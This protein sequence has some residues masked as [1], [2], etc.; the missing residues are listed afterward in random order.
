MKEFSIDKQ[1]VPDIMKTT[2]PEGFRWVD[3]V[4]NNFNSPSVQKQNK[5]KKLLNKIRTEIDA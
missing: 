1:Y 2:L 5:K 3:Y 4:G